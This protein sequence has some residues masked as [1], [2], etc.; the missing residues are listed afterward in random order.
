MFT[1]S[2]GIGSHFRAA[3]RLG[4]DVKA[5]T[6]QRI[7]GDSA[8]KAAVEAL[9]EC[10]HESTNLSG[11]QPQDSYGRVR[12]YGVDCEESKGYRKGAET[13][14]AAAFRELTK[15]KVRSLTRTI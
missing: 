10:I 5:R 13:F 1:T 2:K 6:S 4:T 9:T 8:V 14:E 11:R 3:P 15:G 7:V 12:I